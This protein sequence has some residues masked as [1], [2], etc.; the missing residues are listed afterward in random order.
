MLHFCLQETVFVSVVVY[1]CID[2]NV[3]ES[4]C[5]D[6]M[7]GLILEHPKKYDHGLHSIVFHD[8]SHHRSYTYPSGGPFTD[9]DEL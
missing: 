5:D 2:Y 3:P 7:C 9:M 4:A 6:Y 1:S 8:V